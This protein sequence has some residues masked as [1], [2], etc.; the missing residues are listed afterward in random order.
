MPVLEIG[1][2]ETPAGGPGGYKGVGEG[3]AIGAVPAV[4]NAISDALGTDIDRPVRPSD[5]LAI[6]NRNH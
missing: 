6:A 5:I 1:H 3:G 4:R 2:L